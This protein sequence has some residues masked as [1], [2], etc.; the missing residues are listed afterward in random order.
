MLGMPM[1]PLLPPPRRIVVR[2][3]GEM[4]PDVCD[5]PEELLLEWT[6]ILHRLGEP[7]VII[8]DGVAQ[9]ARALQFA[10]DPHAVVVRCTGVAWTQRELAPFKLALANAVVAAGASF[11]E[12]TIEF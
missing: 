7:I 9:G 1:L 11:V 4:W 5:R 10:R 8:L 6:T 12:A 2:G 3:A